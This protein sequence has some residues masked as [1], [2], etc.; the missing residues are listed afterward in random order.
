MRIYMN[1]VDEHLRSEKLPFINNGTERAII[2][3]IF[4]RAMAV[5]PASYKPYYF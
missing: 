3:P 4:E 1:T 2:Y 5:D